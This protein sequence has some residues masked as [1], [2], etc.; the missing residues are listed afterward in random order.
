MSQKCH[1]FLAKQRRKSKPRK[2]ELKQVEDLNDCDDVWNET[3][4][5][6]KEDN[7]RNDPTYA[8]NQKDLEKN[9]TQGS[10]KR[11]RK[12][13]KKEDESTN[14]GNA[15]ADEQEVKDNDPETE[16][17][18]EKPP[19]ECQEQ[20][21]TIAG[22]WVTAYRVKERTNR[23]KMKQTKICEFYFWIKIFS[24]DCLQEVIFK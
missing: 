10:G 12:R 19:A 11:L 7:E 21:E 20:W 16:K 2:K 3:I 8:A 23:E 1:F 17:L 22:L 13:M 6:E 14:A 18:E 9:L 24:M 15:A 4:D 5:D